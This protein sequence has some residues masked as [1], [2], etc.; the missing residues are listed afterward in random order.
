M[1]TIAALFDFDGV[2]MDTEA[3]YTLF[4]NEQGNVY[5]GENNFGY[6]IKG[7]TLTQIYNKYFL[8]KEAIQQEITD[9][10]DEF[11]KHMYYEYIP[12]VKDFIIDMKRNC[13]KIAIVTSSNEKKMK[14]VYHA[15]PEL[16]ELV[17]CILT[18]EMFIKSKPSPDC[19]LAAMKLLDI[20]PENTYVFEDSFHGLQAGIASGAT[21][22]GLATTNSRDDIKG[23]AHFIID[24]FVEMTYDKLLAL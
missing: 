17:D 20:S 2:I 6:G 23:K 24:D 9:K 8:G 18:S 12:G 19:F 3:Q 22:I 14:N 11:E 7:Q 10:L 1:R 16:R 21:V 13:A 5:L 4:W 15:H